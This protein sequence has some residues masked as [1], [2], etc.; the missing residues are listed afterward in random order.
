MAEGTQK[1]SPAG[2]PAAPAK[3]KAPAAA[4][5]AASKATA[6]NAGATASAPEGER[7]SVEKCKQPI[8]AKGYC[9]KH[10]QAWRRGDLGNKHRYKTCSKEGCRKPAQFAGRCEEHRKGA[11]ETAAAA[12]G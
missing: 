1:K 3:E 10:F 4:A 12:A 2:K 11:G 7:C 5:K 9:R 6:K 8:R